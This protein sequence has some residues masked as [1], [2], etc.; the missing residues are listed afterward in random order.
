MFACVVSLVACG[1]AATDT[2]AQTDTTIAED[3]AS[4]ADTGSTT[5]EPDAVPAGPDTEASSPDAGSDGPVDD[6]PP[7][8]TWLTPPT[9]CEAPADLPVD[10]LVL[11]G[12]AEPSGVQG[13]KHLLDIV[14]GPEDGRLYAAGIPTLVI[15]EDTGA[16]P[17]TLGNI[18][19]RV[20]HVAWAGS[21]R[22][23]LT[24]RGFSSKSGGGGG[25][26]GGQ[27]EP[28]L[29]LAD[30]S[31]AMEPTKAG[32][33][34]LD[35]AAGMAVQGDLLYLV[36]HAGTLHTFDISGAGDPVQLHE[37]SGLGNPWTLALAGS[38]A[39]VADNSVG[40]VV[41]DLGDP[42]APVVGASVAAAGGAQDVTV[43]G[44]VLFLAVGSRGIEAFDLSDPDVPVSL[45]LTDTGVAVIS[46]A[47]S[48][49]LLWF[50][51][52][53]S[54]GVMDTSDPTALLSLGVEDTPSWAMAVDADGPRGYVADWQAVGVYEVYPDS[55]A[56][57]AD[58]E[59][60]EY[61]FVGTSAEIVV[62]LDNRGG[63]PLEIAGLSVDDP[64]VEVFAD[65]LEVAPGEAA[66]VRLVFTHDDAPLEAT[67]CLA[68]NDP[69][70]PV[71]TFPVASTSSDPNAMVG[72]PAPDFNLP[73]LDGTYQ[74]LG[75]QLGKPV[76]LCYFAT[77]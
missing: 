6:P 50:S 49:G 60:D 37:V 51:T 64:R 12:R 36:T 34:A 70:E 58:P 33:Y 47:A 40:L 69:D 76:V 65:R 13:I 20:E 52:Q 9:T 57:D 72:E 48:E 5:V 19:G 56:P 7:E 32:F 31:N 14:I 59:R 45:G 66:Q 8:V 28:G 67:L 26:G 30:V 35:D 63:A 73:A 74:Q 61:F 77:W 41:V 71:Q 2:P 62:S 10:S 29:Y 11:L 55:L 68:T 42:E 39:Y 53:Q 22:V 18:R 27:G 54:V 3:G 1:D 17:N 46:V 15:M 25:G 24:S 75:Q 21:E 16:A 38:R 44:D 43:D 23:A 4:A